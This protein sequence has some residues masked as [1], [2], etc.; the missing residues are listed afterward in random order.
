MNCE[1]IVEQRYDLF[2]VSGGRIMKLIKSL[3]AF[4]FVCGLLFVGG[5]EA[6]AFP[7]EA[8]DNDNMS[9]AGS[10]CHSEQ[11]DDDNNDD[12]APVLPKVPVDHSAYTTDA[13]CLGCHNGEK[14]SDQTAHADDNCLGCHTTTA[15]T[16]PTPLPTWHEGEDF[17]A[18]EDC[19]GCHGADGD[20]PVPGHADGDNCLSCH[21]SATATAPA[22]KPAGH[23]AY[24]AEECASC[25]DADGPGSDQTEHYP[26]G[27][28]DGCHVETSESPTP[29]AKPKGHEGYTEADCAGCHT[30]YGVPDAEK[31]FHDTPGS[32]LVCHDETSTEAPVAPPDHYSGI[33]MG[34]FANNVGADNAEGGSCDSCHAVHGS[35]DA[36]YLTKDVNGNNQSEDSETCLTCHT[37]KIESGH[38]TSGCANCHNIHGPTAEE[39]E[40]GPDAECI[41]CHTD[42]IESGH[43]ASDCISCH[44]PD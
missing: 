16:A 10:S 37:D 21:E 13:S 29:P 4:A 12:A 33:H 38:P 8:M 26:P 19:E 42:K 25:H 6:Y 20:Y 30:S 15:E 41:S 34:G 1:I 18:A 22:V 3:A 9:C 28:C 32:C 23:E 43:Y 35:E 5:T 14:A 7:G 2:K 11:G 17:D 24:T 39:V 27:S 31:S 44:K 36:E 40:A